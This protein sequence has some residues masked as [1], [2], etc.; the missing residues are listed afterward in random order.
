[1]HK[2]QRKERGGA[3]KACPLLIFFIAK[4]DVRKAFKM[5]A[6]PLL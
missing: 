5:A 1:M 3:E 6:E 2:L 4:I